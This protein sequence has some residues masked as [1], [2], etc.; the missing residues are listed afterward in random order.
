MPE[1]KFH[2][3]RI[4]LGVTGSIAA[5]KAVSLVRTLVREGGDV[6]VVMTDSATRFVAP[7]TFEV[8]SQHPVAR[9]LFSNH[10]VMPHLTLSESADLFLI[11][12]AT[13]NT[14]T[15]C[16]LGLADDLLSTMVLTAR[17]PL[18]VAPAMDGGMWDHPTVVEHTRVLRNRGVI[19]LDPEEGPL[20]SGHH[21]VGRFPEEEKI[22]GAMISVLLRRCDWAGHRVLVSAGPTR[23]PID[24][25]RFI[26][27]PSSGKMGY[28]LARAAADRGAEVVLVSGPTG[29]PKPAG[30]DFVPVVTAEDMH[31][32][33]A[34]KFS[35]ATMLVM[36]A[37]VGDFR[38]RYPSRD[39]IKKKTW[40]GEPVEVEETID[41]LKALSPQRT[42]QLMVGFAAETS[43]LVE[44]GKE[45]LEQKDLDLVVINSVA[46]PQS[47][48]GDD[49]NEVILLTRN[50]EITRLD[51]MPKRVLAD[52][53]LDKVQ[54]LTAR[55]RQDIGRPPVQARSV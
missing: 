7:L 54:T 1:G 53:I 29:L 11:A 21:G 6:S 28:A 15:K 13:A 40:T 22:L 33:L 48:F 45:K 37:A 2:G 36:A 23:E 10:E 50:G 24:A 46:G 25:V 32:A 18:I 43:D 47:A 38:P 16:A 42:H 34:A 27:N 20:A 49:T 41:I 26:S 8:L 14:L 3:K 55:V 12:P 17:C 9:D 30:V 4:V 52:R 51:R 5:Y 39:K 44:N 31:Q 19:V 35:W